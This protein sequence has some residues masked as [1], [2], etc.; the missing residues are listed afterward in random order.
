VRVPVPGRQTI[1]TAIPFEVYA[2]LETERGDYSMS[3]H[4]AAILT[5]YVKIMKEPEEDKT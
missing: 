2:F 5:E 1:S 3:T 4:V